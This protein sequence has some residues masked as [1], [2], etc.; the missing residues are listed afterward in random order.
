MFE[1]L[2]E[3]IDNHIE[4]YNGVRLYIMSSDV[5]DEFTLKDLESEKWAYLNDKTIEN[6]SFG[7]GTFHIDLRD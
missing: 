2:R 5:S 6:W 1:T 7:F 3:F 4:N